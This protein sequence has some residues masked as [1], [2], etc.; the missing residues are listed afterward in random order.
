MLL[1]ELSLPC[2]MWIILPISFTHDGIYRKGYNVCGRMNGKYN[3]AMHD[4]WTFA[5]FDLTCANNRQIPDLGST[6][7]YPIVPEK[8]TDQVV[9]L[10]SL[11]FDGKGNWLIFVSG[12]FFSGP[13]RSSA[14]VT[15]TVGI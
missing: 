12:H 13:E 7:H 4:C 1:E 15:C 8:L 14:R 6:G 11:R 2:S 9:M 3:G 10:V 5:G